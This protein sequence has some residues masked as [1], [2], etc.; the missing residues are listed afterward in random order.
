M[1]KIVKISICALMLVSGSVFVAHANF[2]QSTIFLKREIPAKTIQKPKTRTTTTPVVAPAVSTKV[3]APIQKSVPVVVSVP[4]PLAPISSVPQAPI[5]I[6]PTPPITAPSIDVP[7]AKS[8]VIV[9]VPLY[10]TI[11]TPVVHIAEPAPVV[12]AVPVTPLVVAPPTTPVAPLT[13]VQTQ[14]HSDPAQPLAPQTKAQVEVAIP[15]SINGER[16]EYKGVVYHVFFI[17]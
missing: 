2:S 9:P 17:V 3:L 16:E 10:P 6:N 7:P 14:S 15:N 8:E 4:T 12:V 5:V 13:N 11:P 1:S